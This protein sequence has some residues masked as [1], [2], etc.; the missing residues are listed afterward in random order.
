MAKENKET[1]QN[2]AQV[3]VQEQSQ[4]PNFD[5]WRTN[6]RGKY[7][8]D[9]TDE[10]LYDLSMS[11]YDTEHDAVKRYSAEATE[12]EDI[13][14]A[15]PDLAGVFSEI[16]TRGKDGNPAGALR[17]LPPELKRYITDENYGD[18]AYL[19][20]KKAREDEA[21][22]K[23]AKEEQTQSLRE[24]A[25]DEVCQEDGVADPEAALEALKGVLYNPCE[26]LDQCK[27]Q[28][29]AFLKMV[30]YDNAV[31]AAEVRGRNANIA[32]QRKK[33]AGGTD[34]QANRASAAGGTGTQENPLAHMAEMG[35]RARNL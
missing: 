5:K 4:T 21:T 18:E 12:L 26:T 33:S 34:G 10:E 22:A 30:D 13:L 1:P 28:V 3:P 32:A 15:N 25:F 31:E 23:K 7:G 9:K 16:F 6:M 24:Q 17:N 2:E 19:A 20:D 29:R 14:S 8:E 35:A 11:G 27:E